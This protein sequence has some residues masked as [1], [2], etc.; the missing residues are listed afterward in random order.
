MKGT[1]LSDPLFQIRGLVKKYGDRAVLN[2]L[3][4]DIERGECL[5]ILG[6]S[7]S[8]KSVALRQLNGL[9]KPDAGSVVFAGTNLS[10]L[11]ERALF[12]FRRRIAML[13]QS[14]ALFDSMN[15]RDNI[16]FP[17]RE[18]TDLGEEEIGE[19]VRQR[20]GMV[21]LKDVEQKMPSE[22]SGGM[23]KRVALARSLALDPEAVLFD[24]P[25]TGLDPTTSATIAKLIGSVREKLGVTAVVV[26]HDLA[27]ARH[28]G[29]RLAFLSSGH[30]TFLGDWGAADRTTD[31]E[32][33]DF[34][35][36]REEE[37]EDEDA[38]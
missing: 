9:E 36:G 17:L 24:E 19:K 25:T 27:L 34:L 22:L 21:H 15:V 16:A 6:R 37:E 10:V 23:R 31:R 13:F 14:G 8:G 7:G 35:A 32:F 30:F 12:P 3:D 4:F 38:A 1:S 29:D 28:V 18:H 5:V 33:A 26:T 20:L 11:E 2:G